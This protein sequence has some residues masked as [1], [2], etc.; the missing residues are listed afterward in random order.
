M[1]EKLQNDRY[2]S[3]LI[4]LNGNRLNS[5]VQRQRWAEWMK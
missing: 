5:P 4:T 2:K 1:G 3:Y